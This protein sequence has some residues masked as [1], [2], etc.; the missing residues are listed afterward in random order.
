MSA[1]RR[2]GSGVETT[3]AKAVRNPPASVSGNPIRSSGTWTAHRYRFS[4]KEPSPR[5]LASCV[6]N[7]GAA[8]SFSPAPNFPNRRCR[9]RRFVSR[10]FHIRNWF[11]RRNE[12]GLFQ[13]LSASGA[14]V[15]NRR[16]DRGRPQGAPSPSRLVRT[17]VRCCLLGPADLNRAKNS[18]VDSL[19]ADTG[20]VIATSKIHAMRE[21]CCRHEA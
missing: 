11:F 1:V 10:K 9:S 5:G 13:V 21:T 14:P 16:N 3:S 4:D 12:L 8:V 15:R 20:S 2:P 17:K 7:A 19:Y 18:G 6:L